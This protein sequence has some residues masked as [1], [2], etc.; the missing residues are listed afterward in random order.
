MRIFINGKEHETE[1]DV[2]LLDLLTSLG[3]DPER[4]VI[5]YNARVL[6]RADFPS[7][8]LHN[9]DKLELLQFVGGG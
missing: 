4:V 9:D 1:Q 8:P 2:L 7:L 5:E 6:A 3:V